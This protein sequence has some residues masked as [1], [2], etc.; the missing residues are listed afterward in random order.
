MWVV[1][2]DAVVGLL[3]LEWGLAHLLLLLRIGAEVYEGAGQLLER[4]DLVL[5]VSGG[6]LALV[7]QVPKLGVGVAGREAVGLVP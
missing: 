1:L 7:L 5:E 2:L 3:L 4:V 6:L